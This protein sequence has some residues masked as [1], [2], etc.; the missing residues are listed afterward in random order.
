MSWDLWAAEHR[1][2]RE[3]EDLEHQRLADRIGET[4]DRLDLLETARSRRG[5]RQ[6]SL[7][8][9][10]LSALVLPLLVLAI[11]AAATALGHH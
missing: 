3:R 6:W 11:V 10:V 1:A 2:L 5:E 9:T 4:E 7:L 8:I